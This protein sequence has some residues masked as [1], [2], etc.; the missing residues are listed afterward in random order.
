MPNDSIPIEPPTD[1]AIEFTVRA[2]WAH[3]R[4]IDTTTT[5]QSYRVIPPTTAMGL[6]AG[7]LGYS[8]DSYY[9]TFSMSNAAFAIIVEDSVDPFQVA[10]LDLSTTKG[11]FE[12]GRKKGAL[13]NLIARDTTLDDRQ[14]RLYEYLRDPTYRIV[15]SID[16]EDI[17][18]DLIDRLENKEFVYT[19]SLGR[20]ECLAHISDW[21]EYQLSTIEADTVDSTAPLGVARATS[22][23]S[24]ERT[25]QRLTAEKHSRKTTDFVSYAFSK[26]GE[27]TPIIETTEAYSGGENKLLF[28]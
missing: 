7:M 14:Q 15:A 4:R 28:V 5:K 11:D 3:F 26:A 21:N 1:H 12:S 20:S 24:V 2:K 8:R 17:R 18:S 19:P 10:K 9:D 16:D 23:V 27:E 6:I 13:R 25:P 22:S